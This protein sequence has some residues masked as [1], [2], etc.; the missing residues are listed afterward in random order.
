MIKLSQTGFQKVL[1]C[2]AVVAPLLLSSCA[3][4]ISS[5]TYADSH[6]GEATR[7]FRGKVASVRQVRVESGDKLQ[8]NT[9]GAAIGGIAGGIA[10]AQFGGGRGQLA[11]AGAGAI[12]GG[13]LGAAGQRELS[14]QDALEYVVELDSGEMRTVVQGLDRALSVG[15]RVLVMISQGGRSRV[16]PDTSGGGF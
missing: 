1:I 16:V 11:A 9:A 12:L 10:G 15:Q 7:T 13:L 14:S 3:R 5:G 4:Q 2:C 8:D 6:V